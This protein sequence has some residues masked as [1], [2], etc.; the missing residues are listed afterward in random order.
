MISC[1]SKG[2]GCLLGGGRV[3]FFWQER[4]WLGGGGQAAD[5]VHLVSLLWRRPGRLGQQPPLLLKPLRLQQRSQ[6]QLVVVHLPHRP[7]GRFH[8]R[9]CP[10]R[11]PR[12]LEGR[13][14][15][16]RWFGNLKDFKRLRKNWRNF[17]RQFMGRLLESHQQWK[18]HGLL[19]MRW[20]ILWQ[21]AL[22]KRTQM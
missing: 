13:E 22:R 11:H 21:Y 10:H 17:D 14:Q 1:S 8:C 5:A 15:S 20:H 7:A 18:K 6:A 9:L 19:L 3:F 4:Y 12:H 16:Q 2:S